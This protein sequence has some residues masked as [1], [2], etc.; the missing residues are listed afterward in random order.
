MK[1]IRQSLAWWC[2]LRD[3]MTPERLL[4][5]AVE[6]G[7]EAVELVDEAYWP[8]VK[9][10]GLR[11]ASIGGHESLVKGLNRREHHERIEKEILAK[12]ALAEKWEIPNLIVFSG[13][14]EGLDDR[15]GAEITAEGLRRV[16]AA[17]ERAGVTLVLEL[18]NSKVDHPGYQCDRS[19]WGVEVCRMVNSPRVKL[20]YDIYH[21]QIME[22]DII[23]TIREQHAF[24]GHYHTAGNPGRHEINATQEINYAPIMR[25]ILE[26]G[27]D[28][29]VGQ[30]F[31]PTGDTVEALKQAFAICNVTIES[32]NRQNA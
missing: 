31:V 29:F 27:Y 18:L 23:R 14:R 26:T 21:M 12:L 5:T 28:G 20:L 19:A 4:R 9:Q 2:Y 10:Y 6:I 13:S 32:L 7:Y 16:S 24:F 1:R 15:T 17:A 11:I 30:E 25:A 22:G 3:T 8:L